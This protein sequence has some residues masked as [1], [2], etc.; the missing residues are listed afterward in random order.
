MLLRQLLQIDCRQ[1]ASGDFIDF[2]C[3]RFVNLF[4]LIERPCVSIDLST[5]SRSPGKFDS[6]RDEFRGLLVWA[7]FSR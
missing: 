5:E 3:D 2:L 7:M 1:R 6:Q 4:E